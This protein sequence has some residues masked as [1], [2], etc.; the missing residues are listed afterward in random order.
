MRL[1]AELMDQNKILLKEKEKESK[2]QLKSREYKEIG[3]THVIKHEQIVRSEH[4]LTCKFILSLH[5]VS[6][7]K[8]KRMLIKNEFS[9]ATTTTNTIATTKLK[10]VFIDKE[11]WKKELK[12]NILILRE[13]FVSLFSRSCVQN[14]FSTFHFKN[15]TQDTRESKKQIKAKNKFKMENEDLLL[16]S[17]YYE[18]FETPIVLADCGHSVCHKFTLRLMKLNSIRSAVVESAVQK[19]LKSF[20]QV[21]QSV[22]QQTTSCSTSSSTT[23]IR[24]SSLSCDGFV[25]IECPSCAKPNKFEVDSNGEPAMKKNMDLIPLIEKYRRGEC[26]NEFGKLISSYKWVPI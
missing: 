1:S 2:L 25:T 26:E 18:I 4:M 19:T 12:F 16:C 11:R 20:K 6:Y 23:S 24:A 15:K 17:F 21:D 5:T 22:T 14:K 7:L 13:N 8:K 3:F 10:V 9:T